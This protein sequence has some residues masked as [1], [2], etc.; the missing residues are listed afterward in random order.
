MPTLKYWDATLGSWQALV[1]GV[2]VFRQTA[3]Y[4][5]DFP[6]TQTP[7]NATSFGT[8]TG[9]SILVYF[10]P[11]G[12]ASVNF[13]AQVGMTGVGGLL[14]AVGI[15]TYPGGVV[16]AAP[17]DNYCAFIAPPVTGDGPGFLAS[18][19]HISTGGVA[20]QFAVAMHYKVGSGTAQM[21]RRRITVTPLDLVPK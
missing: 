13:Y 8:H 19:F 16:V 1:G 21:M 2:P 18:T 6:T 7:I 5:D 3:Y 14:A 10:G 11:S 12:V 20:G 4:A 17:S 9:P 15:K